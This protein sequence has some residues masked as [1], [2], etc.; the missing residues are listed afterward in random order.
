MI[1]NLFKKPLQECLLRLAKQEELNAKQ[2]Q[3]F[4][5]TRDEEFTPLFSFGTSRGKK[6]GLTLKQILNIKG[7]DPFM[8]EPIAM[9]KLKNAFKAEADVQEIAGSDIIFSVFTDSENAGNLKINII[10]KNSINR[11]MTLEQL[12]E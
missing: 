1:V 7:I 5:Y 12:M 10:H 2:V 3:I 8:R 4:I 9:S 6:G 11:T